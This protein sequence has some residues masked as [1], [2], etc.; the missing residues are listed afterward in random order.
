MSSQLGGQTG[1]Q[2]KESTTGMRG[3]GQLRGPASWSGAHTS[4][5]GFDGRPRA[6]RSVMENEFPFQFSSDCSD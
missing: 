4:H 2:P 1:G 5:R 6:P 3:A